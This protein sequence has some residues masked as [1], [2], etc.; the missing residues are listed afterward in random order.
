MAFEFPSINNNYTTRCVVVVVVFTALL[1][2]PSSSPM[3]LPVLELSFSIVVVAASIFLRKWRSM[4]TNIE[5]EEGI[6]SAA[7]SFSVL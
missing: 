5:E 3:L 2:S 1:Q 4:R 7:A 6:D